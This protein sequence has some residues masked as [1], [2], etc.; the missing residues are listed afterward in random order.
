MKGYRDSSSRSSP[1]FGCLEKKRS[2]TWKWPIPKSNFTGALGLLGLGP[3]LPSGSRE[4]VPDM[5]LMDSLNI[6]PSGKPAL[7][8]APDAAG[9]E[10]E[11]RASW[12]E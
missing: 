8:S 7:T 9:T 10:P 1:T 4:R 6:M 2:L 3:A 12:I 5:R 11:A